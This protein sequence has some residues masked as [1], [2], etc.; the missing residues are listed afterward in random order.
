MSLRGEEGWKATH[1]KAFGKERWREL[2]RALKSPVDHVAL[3]SCF[4]SEETQLRLKAE[5][6]L[7]DHQ[8]IPLVGVLPA[9]HAHQC[10]LDDETAEDDGSALKAEQTAAASVA[11]GQAST[12]A[13]LLMDEPINPCY[14]MDGASVV[15]ALALGVEAGDYVLDLC[16]A[17]GG[18]ALVLASLLFRPPAAS[19]STSGGGYDAQTETA[20]APIVEA[21]AHPAPTTRHRATGTVPIEV[22]SLV[23][24]ARPDRGTVNSSPVRPGRLVCNESSKNRYYRLRRVLEGFL[25]PELLA[26]SGHQPVHVTNCDAATGTGAPPVAL[27]RLGPFDKVLVDAPCTSDRHL[28]KQGTIALSKRAAGA[29]KANAERQLELLGCAAK[30]VKRGGVIL[31]CTC[32]LSSVE[33]DGVVAKFLKKSGDTFKTESVDNIKFPVTGFEQT[34]LGTLFMPDRSSYGPIYFARCVGF[35]RAAFSAVVLLM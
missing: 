24:L 3:V 4:V 12:E 27:Q 8:H 1:Q 18:K 11:K 30:L 35:D 7:R 10:V 19:P 25:S 20:E 15:A 13:T 22:H 32:A 9:G 29:V 33:N 26:P 6:E 17:P 34:Q 14:F 21:A 31:Y 23:I 5:H 16:S 2:H 28:A